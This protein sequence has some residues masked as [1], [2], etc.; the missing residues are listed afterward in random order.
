MTFTAAP[1]A[2]KDKIIIGAAN[3]DQGVRDWIAGLDAETGKRL[4]RNFT[5]PAPGE[6]GS[7]T[8]KDNNNAWQTGGGAVWVTGTYDP[9]TNQT[10]WGTGNPV[11][12]F[13]PTYRPGDNLFTNSAISC[14]PDTGKMNWYFQFTPGDMWDYDEVGTHILI[15]G[16]VGGQP[17]KL[18][19]HS[20]RNGF[21]YTMERANG[22]DRARQAL[23][24]GQLDQ[25]HRPEDRQAARLR[26]DQGHPD[27]CGRRQPHP[28]RA[29]Q[30]GLPVASR[31]QQLLA[32]VLQPEDQAPLHPGFDDLRRPSP[33]T[34][35]S[36]PSRRA[37]TA[38]LSQ[39]TERWESNLTAVDP[40][41]G[42]IKKTVHAAVSELLRHARDRRRPRV[43]RVARRHRRWLMTTPPS[44]SCGRSTSAPASPRR[45]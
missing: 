10:I 24:G 23:H 8:W 7:E 34:P 45:R 30:E 12:M 9:A 38:G 3:G 17:R 28:G 36:T 27:L 14:N 41:T 26:S 37:G 42:E 25:G 2:I 16:E 35:R 18:I 40:L 5:V 19:T 15:D 22:A 4:W 21:L 13:D 1:L 39:T 11:P 43:H 6:P 44:T 33:S 31:R 20:A 32:V 29:A